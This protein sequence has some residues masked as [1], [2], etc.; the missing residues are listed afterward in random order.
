MKVS[1]QQLRKI[2]KEEKRKVI[3]EQ[4]LPGGTG[5]LEDQMME[6]LEEYIAQLAES[7]EAGV[8]EVETLITQLVG[9]AIDIAT[10]DGVIK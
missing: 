4:G 6:M 3:L 1:K 8:V 9:R 10:R 2:I 7:G 5:A